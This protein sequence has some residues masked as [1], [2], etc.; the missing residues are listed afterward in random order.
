M[1][2]IDRPPAHGL[3]R[4]AL[5]TPDGL[6]ATLGGTGL[7][8][9]APGTVGSAV[10]VVPAWFLVQQPLWL[11]GA[12]IVAAL[13]LGIWACGVFG[14]RIGSHDHG[15][16]VWDE[17]V[18]IWITLLAAPSSLPIMITGFVLFR[19]FDIAKPP[20]ISWIDRRLGGGLGVMADDVV[21][22]LFAFASLRLVIWL[23]PVSG[24]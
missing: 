16:V 8:R 22:G 6:I 12:A 7:A 19:F 14:R 9:R 20:P 2:G 5:T 15:A 1:D 3:A 24:G 18:G 11:Q 13:L 23:A 4:Q 17:L 10:A 21:A